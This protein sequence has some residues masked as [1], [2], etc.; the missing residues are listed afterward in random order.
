[1]QHL[2]NITT[3]EKVKAA[4]KVKISEMSELF[5]NFIYPRELKFKTFRDLVFLNEEEN[6]M[7]EL[8]AFCHF[9]DNKTMFHQFVFFG[10]N[11]HRLT[12][13]RLWLLHNYIQKKTQQS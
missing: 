2:S 10:M 3:H 1:M 8:P 13:I 11:D 12:Q 9:M 6:L 4:I 5:V 7:V